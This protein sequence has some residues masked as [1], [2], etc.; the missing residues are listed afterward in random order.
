[1]HCT[2]RDLSRPLAAKTVYALHANN[3]IDIE[4]HVRTYAVGVADIAARKGSRHNVLHLSSSN[5]Y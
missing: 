1:M 4:L 3:A 2:G 5:N